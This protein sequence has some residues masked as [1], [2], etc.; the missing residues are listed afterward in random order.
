VLI[1]D[2][3]AV[4]TNH[5]LVSDATSIA[6]TLSGGEEYDWRVEGS[7][8]ATDLAVVRIDGDGFPTTQFGDSDRLKV[9]QQV[10]AIGNPLG[11]QATVTAG[12]ISGLGRTFRTDS[13]RLVEGVIQ[14]DAALNPGNSGG[15][16]INAQ[17]QVVGI[18]TAIILPAQNICLAVPSQTVQWV[19]DQLL[20]EEKV[21]RAFMGISGYSGKLRPDKRQT[22]EIE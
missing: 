14:A 13:D 17:T 11:F 7:D 16:L 22:L 18:N 21:R 19:V 1:T 15:P 6:V 9:G 10:I 8:P 4:V 20:G 3:G 2:D 12:I 5:H